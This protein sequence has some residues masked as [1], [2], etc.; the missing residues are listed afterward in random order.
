[1]ERED[2]EREEVCSVR[3][4]GERVSFFFLLEYVH[5]RERMGIEQKSNPLSTHNDLTYTA[6][7]RGSLKKLTVEIC[8]C[9]YMGAQPHFFPLI[10]EGEVIF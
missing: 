8:E 9:S 10:I 5:V 2:E 4:S 7:L 1:L 6:T 3:F